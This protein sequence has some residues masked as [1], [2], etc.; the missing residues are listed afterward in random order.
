MSILTRILILLL[1]LLVICFISLLFFEICY[2]NSVID[3]YK[4]ETLGLNSTE[5]L[6]EAQADL[7]VFGDSFSATSKTIN[8][9]DRLREA[10]PEK[11]I[12]NF[13]IPGTGI[14]QLNTLAK[15]KIKKYQPKAILYQIY[16]GNDLL[17]V[18]KFKTRNNVSFL[19]YSFWQ[20]SNTFLSLSYLNHKANVLRPKVTYRHKTLTI[21][22][23]SPDYY[24]KRSQH[25]VLVNS[26]YLEETVS[27]SARFKVKYEKW[28]RE[29]KTLLDNIP[30]ETKVY[31]VWIPHCA[32]VNDYYLNNFKVLNAEFK[33]AKQYQE[34]NY[35][36]LNNAEQDLKSYHNVKHINTLPVFRGED[37]LNRR[38][39][40][41]NDPHLNK[42]GNDVLANYL[43][44]DYFK[45]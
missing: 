39:F 5:D 7:L 29:I 24:N 23:F 4:T 30:K 16:V 1:K 38:I 2:R 13:S 20:A 14:R 28:L 9:V 15:G 6:K 19:K 26:N 25:D 17:D 31:F 27:I 40:F 45:D 21:A 37:E 35:P 8:Y 32:Q 33:N 10:N 43:N 3:F 11:T 42:F 36:F 41:A 22:D 44:S 18:E 12:L 34:L